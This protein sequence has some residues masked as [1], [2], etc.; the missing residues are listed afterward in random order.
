MKFKEVLFIV[1]NILVWVAFISIMVNTV[2]K[3]KEWGLNLIKGNVTVK[4]KNDSKPLIILFLV[5][6]LD[7]I[8]IIYDVIKGN[9]IQMMDYNIVV[10]L[11][12]YLIFYFMNR[13]YFKITQ[14]GIIYGINFI[15]WYNVKDYKWEEE[16]LKITIKNRGNESL[17]ECKVDPNEK[18]N[19]NRILR[20][21]RIYK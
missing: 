12:V 19:I 10:I 8:L 13:K 6:V 7:V 9:K 18:Q 11:S 14:K 4:S 3:R 1:F 21:R 2:M 16:L 5:V 20:N 15:R 17:L